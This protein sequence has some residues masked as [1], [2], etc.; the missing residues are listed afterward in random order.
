VCFILCEVEGMSGLVDPRKAPPFEVAN[1]AA[2]RHGA[3]VSSWRLAPRAE[4]IAAE[5]AELVPASSPSDGPT[6]SLLATILCRLEIANAYVERNGLFDARGRPR[7]IV[8]LV[9]TWENSAGRLLDQLGMSPTSRAR[10]GLDLTRARGEA[11][12]A[13]LE[14]HYE[15]P[16]HEAE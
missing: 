9:S 10:L 13:H 12:R 1:L 11:L 4:E 5:L 16:A 3:Q 14:E 15:G 2:R 8:R 7:P 6:V